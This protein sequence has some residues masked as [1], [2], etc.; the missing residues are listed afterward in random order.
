MSTFLSPSPAPG[1]SPAPALKARSV[2]LLEGAAT[3]RHFR[4][5]RLGNG[6]LQASIRGNRG[7]FER[8]GLGSVFTP[9][10][11]A[12]RC[13][14]LSW[15]TLDHRRFE[16]CICI[17][18]ESRLLDPSRMD[19]TALSN[20]A[21][22]ADALVAF[23]N[24]GYFNH[25]KMADP[26]REEWLAIGPVHTATAELPSLAL[27]DDYREDFHPLSAEDGASIMSAP[28]LSRD[29]RAEF[30]EQLL[31]QARYTAP[32]A[33]PDG[34][35]D[36]RPGSLQHAAARHPRAAISYPASA[37]SGNLRFI[38]GRVAN[39]TQDP[40]TGYS[41]PEWSLACSWLDRRD[42]VGRDGSRQLHNDSLNLDG[43]NSVV[44]GAHLPGRTV[45]FQ[46]AQSSTGRP[47]ANLVVA[48]ERPR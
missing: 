43:G 10:D 16:L 4:V 48:V 6:A 19:R 44:M 20:G 38:V 17:S 29:G 2:A 25:R 45:P 7:V 33:G 37:G 15:M 39:R 18:A 26:T 46:L 35:P 11:L 30:T 40:E 32:A 34:R 22:H 21:A 47:L 9:D 28:L 1:P 3:R 24:G 12:T 13:R 42:G 8:V 41:L 23:I 31:Q 36:I 14:E 27:P 5:M